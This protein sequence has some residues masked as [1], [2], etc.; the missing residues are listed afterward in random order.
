[1]ATKLQRARTLAVIGRTV[2]ALPLFETLCSNAGARADPPDA[3][4]ADVDAAE[5]DARVRAFEAQQSFAWISCSAAENL[6][7]GKTF[8]GKSPN[9]VSGAMSWVHAKRNVEEKIEVLKTMDSEI[10]NV[11]QLAATLATTER[12]ETFAAKSLSAVAVELKDY[13]GESVAGLT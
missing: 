9:E 6:Q 10:A 2:D 4:P 7:S 13:I 12:I 1:M 5:H 8:Y 11:Q 3:A